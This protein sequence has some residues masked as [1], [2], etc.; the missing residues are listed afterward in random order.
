M[1]HFIAFLFLLIP[2]CAVAAGD[3]FSCF[4]VIAGK[5]VTTDGHV[6]MAHN[7]DD[8]G[9]LMV[10]MYAC[11]DYLWEELPGWDVADTFFNRY[12]YR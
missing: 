4:A 7:E 8:P 6:L 1:K 10:S 9:E 2:V 3:E 5:N 12:R 11:P